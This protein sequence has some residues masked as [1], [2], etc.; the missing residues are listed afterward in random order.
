MGKIVGLT[1]EEVPA[2]VCPHCGK[3]YKTPDALAKHI[4]DKHPEAAN[5]SGESPADN[6]PGQ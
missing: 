6:A 4:K 2:L 3:E 5:S 1:F